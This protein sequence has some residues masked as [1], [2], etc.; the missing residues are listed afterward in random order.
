MIN[1]I[2]LNQ[3]VPYKHFKKEG[4]HC[5]IEL[6]I[7]EDFMCK[8]DLNNAYFFVPLSKKPRKLVQFRWSDNLR[9]HKHLPCPRASSL[10]FHKIN[11]YACGTSASDKYTH[12][13][14][15]AD[16]SKGK[17]TEETLMNCQSVIHFFSLVGQ[18][19]NTQT[20]ALV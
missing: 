16:T 11:E 10:V 4:V 3:F 6:L 19:K 7:E 13:L 9:I 1:L 17:R 15:R 2:P 14:R 5:F 12:I 18:S 20:F 8:L